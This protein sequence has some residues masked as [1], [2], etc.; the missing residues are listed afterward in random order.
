[1]W[2]W[3]IAPSG[4]C[5]H[6]SDWS[7]AHFSGDVA[8]L[9]MHVWTSWGIHNLISENPTLEPKTN[10]GRLKKGHP[11]RENNA[12]NPQSEGNNELQ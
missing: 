5:Y 11:Y 8:Q 4:I 1:M 2:L 10:Q 9:A 3:S 12:L 7:S 6:M